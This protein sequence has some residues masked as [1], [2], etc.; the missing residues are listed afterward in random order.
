MNFLYF[1]LPKE[2][3]GFIYSESTLR[4][5]MEK[6]EYHRHTAVPIINK[7]GKYIGVIR[8]GDILWYIKNNNAFNLQI[9]EQI[10]V[11]DIPRSKDHKSVTISA[12]LDELVALAVDQNFIPVVD[13][14]GT[15]I[16]I[17]T[18]KVIITELFKNR[19][20]K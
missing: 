8:E 6:M 5:A 15:F 19:G 2:K 12:D 4:Q 7:K 11:K 14:L 10:L 16:G 13:D 3:V 9:A 17:V 18:R 1:L 20:E